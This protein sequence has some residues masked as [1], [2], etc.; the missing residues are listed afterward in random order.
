MRESR[1]GS[2]GNGEKES[3]CSSEKGMHIC[4]SINQ[5]RKKRKGGKV[6]KPGLLAQNIKGEIYLHNKI[7]YIA[8]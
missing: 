3:L 4:M 7:Q 1:E 6:R 5:C 8:L 2:G